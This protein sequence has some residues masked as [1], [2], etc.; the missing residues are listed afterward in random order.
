MKLNK[1]MYELK[2]L[3]TEHTKKMHITI[4]KLGMKI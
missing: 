4:V 3:G 1:I 2:S